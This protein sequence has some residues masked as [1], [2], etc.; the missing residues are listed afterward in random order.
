MEEEKFEVR[1][2]SLDFNGKYY[3]ERQKMLYSKEEA[4]KFS[5]RMEQQTGKISRVYKITKKKERIY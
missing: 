5:K 3:I 1:Y 4:I 2:Y